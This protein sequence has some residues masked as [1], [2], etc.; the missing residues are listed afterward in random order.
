MSLNRNH[1]T[2]AV[3]TDKARSKIINQIK[4]F[5]PP[6]LCL[7]PNKV[8][9]EPST[10]A[11]SQSNFVPIK[12]HLDVE[13][14]DRKND[15]ELQ[16]TS[17]RKLDQWELDNLT[18]SKNLSYTKK[19]IENENDFKQFIRKVEGN[20]GNLISIQNGIINNVSNN[21]SPHLIRRRAFNAH[22]LQCDN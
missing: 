1:S 7:N 12:F 11:R 10:M 15:I 20:L 2:S 4:R 3:L 17:V 19:R 8:E 22:E 6:L 5:Y 18:S 16:K 21:E 9:Q 13:Q 14:D